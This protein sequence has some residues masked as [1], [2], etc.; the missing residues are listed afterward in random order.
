MQ[1]DIHKIDSQ[2]D[3]QTIL[4]E[5]DYLC[6]NLYVLGIEKI[7]LLPVINYSWLILISFY[8]NKKYKLKIIVIIRINIQVA[9]WQL[10]NQLRL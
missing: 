8:N 7:F 2:L 1:K 4:Q 3:Y 9:L 10:I 6:C 5:D